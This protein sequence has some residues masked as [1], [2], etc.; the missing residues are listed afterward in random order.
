MIMIWSTFIF[1]LRNHNIKPELGVKGNTSLVYKEY[2]GPTLQLYIL[3]MYIQI[4]R[5]NVL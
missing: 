2:L 4:Y 3:H 5:T 1:F